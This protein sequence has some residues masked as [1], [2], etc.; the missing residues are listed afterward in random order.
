ML[1]FASSKKVHCN[2]T[3]AVY[4]PNDFSFRTSDTWIRSRPP[5][6]V[7]SGRVDVEIIEQYPLKEHLTMMLF[8]CLLLLLLG[9]QHLLQQHCDHHRRSRPERKIPTMPHPRQY[10]SWEKI[11]TMPVRRLGRLRGDRRLVRFLR[12]S[13][14]VCVCGSGGWHEYR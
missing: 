12:E 1:L 6:P 14:V 4:S 8:F 11:A 7:L 10:R 13:F 5:P 9:R 3:L 2:C